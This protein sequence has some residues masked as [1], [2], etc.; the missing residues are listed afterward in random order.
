M[1]HTV[2]A[3]RIRLAAMLAALWQ[4]IGGG[5]HEPPAVHGY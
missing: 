5:M 3:G 2:R 1:V 4:S